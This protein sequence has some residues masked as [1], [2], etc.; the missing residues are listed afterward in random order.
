MPV[1]NKSQHRLIMSEFRD[2]YTRIA[3]LLTSREL[4]NSG[5]GCRRRGHWIEPSLKCATVG[6]DMEIKLAVEDFKNIL[7]EIKK[8]K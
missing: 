5:E 8:L 2:R 1:M 7:A 3:H 6:N 4:H